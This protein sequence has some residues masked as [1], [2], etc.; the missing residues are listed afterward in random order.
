MQNLAGEFKKD[1]DHYRAILGPEYEQNIS[2][3]GSE[4]INLIQ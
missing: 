3:Q 2:F 4:A 1:P